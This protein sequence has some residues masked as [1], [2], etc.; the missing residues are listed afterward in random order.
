MQRRRVPVA[1]RGAGNRDTAAGGR[2]QADG[3][4]RPRVF[5]IDHV[6]PVGGDKPDG[7]RNLLGH[8]L[9]QQADQRTKSQAPHHRRAHGNGAGAKPIFLILRQINQLTHPGQRVGQPRHRR[10]RQPATVGDL[11]IAQPRLMA[12]EAAHHVE[13]A[14]HH[15]DDVVVPGAITGGP[16]QPAQAFG[17][18]PHQTD[19]PLIVTGL[20]HLTVVGPGMLLPIHVPLCGIKFLL[21]E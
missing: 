10:A 12:F 1:G 3:V 6:E 17:S 20:A 14:R 15:L 19:P 21:V 5:Q 2:L 16:I 4:V 7:A 18:P 13:G 8:V 11:Q 9:H